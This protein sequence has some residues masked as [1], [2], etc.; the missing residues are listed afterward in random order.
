MFEILGHLP[1]VTLK[2][3][4]IY[5]QRKPR[6]VCWTSQVHLFLLS[7][8]ITVSSTFVSNIWRRR[9]FCAYVQAYLDLCY[10][11]SFPASGNFCHL[12]I[13]FVNS[14]DP[15]QAQQNIG[16]GLDPNCLTLCWYSWAIFFEKV[17]LKKKKKSTD[18]KKACKI[19]QH[20]KRQLWKLL[21]PFCKG[22]CVYT[23]SL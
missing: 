16:P 18:D 13:T 15:D 17:N 7:E 2:R 20:A 14:L 5:E 6:S 3:F 22:V 10:F 19:T 23:V 8:G 21:P 12:L 4:N 9:N 11:N 1:Y